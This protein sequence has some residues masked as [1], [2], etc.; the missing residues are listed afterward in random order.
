MKLNFLYNLFK[1]D[2]KQKL[3]TPDSILIKKIKSVCENN[4]LKV[5]ENTTIYHH[6][7]SILVPL[8]ILDPKRG[9]YILEYKDWT[10]DDLENY[11]LKRSQNNQHSKNTLAYDKINHFINTKFNEILHND[12]VKFFNFLIAENLSFVDYEHLSDEKRHLLPHNKVIF[13][14][15]NE[16]EILK[17]LNSAS[18]VDNSLDEED[19][20]LANLLTQ[21]LVLHKENVS[22]ATNEQINYIID[23]NAHH[24]TSNIVSLNGLAFSGKTTSLI[25]KAIYLKLLSKDNTVT[26]IEP[27]TLS[28]DVVK[29]SILELIEYSIVNID[30]TSIHVYT[31]NEFLDHKVTKYILCDDASLIED[32]LLD[33]IIS[34]SSKSKLTLV[35]PKNRYEHFYKLTKSFHTDTNIEF[36]QCNPYSSAMQKI[37]TY[38]QETDKTILCVSSIDTSEKLNED[39]LT[40]LTSEAILLDSSKNLIDQEESSVVLSDYKNIN[41]QRSDIVILLDICEA[42]QAELSYAI[43]LAY[44]KVF[45]IYE[46]ECDSITTLK[47]IFKKD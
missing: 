24:N 20:I 34:K 46:D 21:Y 33:K 4:N 8:M 47:K 43:N 3:L 10:Y 9:L 39:L 40:Y 25:L 44:E 30:V 26:I 32:N 17:K 28:C 22:L 27:T 14:D 15:N 1:K 37:S 41:A 11:E 42:S 36:V 35:N 16:A 18:E 19:F 38:S 7:Q 6:S 5:L 12:C 29:Q 23:S 31:P 45:L 13:C 2:P